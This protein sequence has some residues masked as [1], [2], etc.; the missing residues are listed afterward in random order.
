[1]KIN[2][3]GVDVIL[4]DIHET[5]RFIKSYQY[6]KPGY[7]CL[8]NVYVIVKASRDASY[9]KVLNSSTATLPDG[10]PIELYSKFK[11]FRNI[12]TVS[13]Y[14]LFN[15]LIETALTHYFYGANE[16]TLGIIQKKIESKFPRANVLGYKAPP[17]VKINEIENNQ[18]IRNDI[19][20][21]NKLQPDIIW[22]G[23]S[24]PKQD[25]LMNKYYNKLNK[26]LMIGVGAV[27]NYIAETYKISPEWMKRLSI[28]WIHRLIQEPRLWKRYLF[29]NIYFIFLIIKELLI[30]LFRFILKP[31][32]QSFK[33]LF[34]KE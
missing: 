11:G 14:L 33:N 9:A 19:D 8:P 34:L 16:E 25:I 22:I 26:G 21:I 28:R 32:M 4:T 17:F 30:K 18:T 2:I 12:S 3:F 29:G 27:F 15:N 31:F 23:I 24:S 7:I 13:G 1:M 6:N 5:T 10:K 20:E